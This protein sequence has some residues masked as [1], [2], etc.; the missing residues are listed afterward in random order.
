MNRI[1]APLRLMGASTR[2]PVSSSISS[3][4]KSSVSSIPRGSMPRWLPVRWQLAAGSTIQLMLHPT[5]F[6]SSRATIVTSA[7]SMPKGQYTAQ[8]RHSVHW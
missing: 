8:R 7:V 5:R 6:N 4:A 3:T 1:S 2:M